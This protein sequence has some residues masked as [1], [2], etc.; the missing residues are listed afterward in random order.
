MPTSK[1][2]TLCTPFGQGRSTL[3]H[4]HGLRYAAL[5]PRLTE[6]WDEKGRTLLD[7]CPPNRE[8]A[9]DGVVGAVRLLHQVHCHAPPGAEGR[10][11][12]CDGD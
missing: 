3:L 11:H 9:G 4:G 7:G 8:E 5:D 1:N 10:E 2:M 6:A 12:L